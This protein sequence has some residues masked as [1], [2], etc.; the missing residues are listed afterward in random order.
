MFRHFTCDAEAGAHVEFKTAMLVFLG[1]RNRRDVE[2]Q[3]TWRPGAL[4]TRWA[5]KA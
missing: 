2:E 1:Q 4:G 3:Y 5:G